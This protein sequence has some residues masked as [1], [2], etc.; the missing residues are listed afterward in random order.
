MELKFDLSPAQSASAYP[1]S[2]GLLVSV[3][4]KYVVPL[5]PHP[6]YCSPNPHGVCAIPSG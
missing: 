2:V 4:L 5:P 3:S 1:D 6:L